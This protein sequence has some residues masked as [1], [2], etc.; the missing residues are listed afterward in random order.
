MTK[1]FDETVRDMLAEGLG[2]EDIA[3]KLGL[4]I[5]SVQLEVNALRRRGEI[6]RIFKKEGRD[7]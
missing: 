2:V 1:R 4:P 5:V 6:G 3:V 7:A